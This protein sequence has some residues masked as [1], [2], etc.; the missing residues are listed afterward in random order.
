[1]RARLE[2]LAA[3]TERPLGFWIEKSID[4]YLPALEKQFAKE[5]AALPN[6]LNP[7]TRKN[8]QAGLRKGISAARVPPKAQQ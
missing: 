2:R 1:M 7:D 5:L 6:S 4:A 8:L 3:A